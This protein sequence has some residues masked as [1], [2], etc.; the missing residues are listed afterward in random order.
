MEGGRTNVED[1]M[2]KPDSANTHSLQQFLVVNYTIYF[3]SL[4]FPPLFE[5]ATGLGPGPG[6][7][8]R[9]RA[10]HHGPGAPRD[11]AP[12]ALA[13]LGDR[14]HPLSSR[15]TLPNPYAPSRVPHRVVELTDKHFSCQYFL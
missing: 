7:G 4:D 6:A 1:T 11:G 14:E 2:W 3:F 15:G 10:G 8:R 13:R 9:R 5:R 12:R